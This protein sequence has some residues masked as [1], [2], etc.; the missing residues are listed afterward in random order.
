M[1]DLIDFAKIYSSNNT[2]DFGRV[3]SY[4]NPSESE[5]NNNKKYFSY[6]NP[7]ADLTKVIE[8]SQNLNFSLN[9]LDNSIK[10]QDINQTYLEFENSENNIIQQINTHINSPINTDLMNEIDEIF[11]DLESNEYL[12]SVPY[13]KNSSMT[14][15][16]LNFYTSSF[17]YSFLIPNLFRKCFIQK[18]IPIPNICPNFEKNN[19]IKNYLPLLLDK[20]YIKG[21]LYFNYSS[22]INNNNPFV[23][24]LTD[25]MKLKINNILRSKRATNYGNYTQAPVLFNY[26]YSANSLLV[27]LLNFN[28]VLNNAQKSYSNQRVIKPFQ[29][30]WN[31]LLYCSCNNN[32][33]NFDNTNTNNPATKLQKV[34][35]QSDLNAI[36]LLNSYI[37]ITPIFQILQYALQVYSDT[38]IEI[39]YFMLS[40]NYNRPSYMNVSN[41]ELLNKLYNNY[42]N[43][44]KIVDEGLINYKC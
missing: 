10:L 34:I 29:I 33:V 28:K 31:V 13:S 2:A 35:N 22:D 8:A 36:N 11:N 3:F 21:F 17:N 30:P 32:V 27:Q 1:S 44:Q 25:I 41:L 43:N 19:V 12:C 5:V 37:K 18:N 6:N 23:S 14:I 20:K 42:E 7:M 16:G 26:I 40:K 39:E 9:K 15:V 4:D 24:S 38:I